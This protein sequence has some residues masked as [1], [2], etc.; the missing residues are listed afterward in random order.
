MHSHAL[1][2]VVGGIVTLPYVERD[3]VATYGFGIVT[4]IFIESLS[5]VA[6]A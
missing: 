6:A 3:V 1:V 4:H 2:E 5:D